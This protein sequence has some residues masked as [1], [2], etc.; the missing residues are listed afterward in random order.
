M[1]KGYRSMD[2]V[3]KN[4]DELVEQVAKVVDNTATTLSKAERKGL[5]LELAKTLGQK[6]KFQRFFALR[7]FNKSF[8]LN[9]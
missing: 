9:K 6:G 1:F 5:E 7:F 2:D 3:L 8:C 4:A